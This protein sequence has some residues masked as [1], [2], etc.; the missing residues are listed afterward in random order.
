MVLLARS[1]RALLS[2]A[3]PV[4]E[5]KLLQSECHPDGSLWLHYQLKVQPR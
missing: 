1:V 5:M 3:P 2:F 4:S